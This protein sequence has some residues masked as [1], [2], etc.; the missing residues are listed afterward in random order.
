MNIDPT[1]LKS[2]I[3]TQYDAGLSEDEIVKNAHM[4]IN[5]VL[6][7]DEHVQRGFERTIKSANIDTSTISSDLINEVASA[8]ILASTYLKK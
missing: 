6:L 4:L 7:E 5:Q 8:T 3:N 2:F 1:V